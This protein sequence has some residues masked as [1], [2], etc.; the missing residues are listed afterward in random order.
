MT[1]TL[2]LVV[3]PSGVGKDTLLDTAKEYLAEDDQYI[4][5]RRII[6]RPQDATGEDHKAV[7]PEEFAKMKARK[8][9]AL[10]WHAHGLDYGIPVSTLRDVANGNT[11][12]V[13]VS[14]TVIA[15]AE[16]KFKAVKVA[17]INAKPDILRQRLLARGRE[18]DQDIEKRID[19]A[20]HYKPSGHNIVHIDNSGPLES[21][22]QSFIRLI[23]EPLSTPAL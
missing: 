4:F 7:T 14:R 1:G 19:R 23:S 10:F 3:G 6:T 20:S 13:N 12:I 9:F 18:T 2:I 15:E 17:Y 5:P 8:T 16:E 11:V 22:V 21:A